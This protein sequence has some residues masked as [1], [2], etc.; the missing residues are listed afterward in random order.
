MAPV[1]V[2]L[3][4]GLNVSQT[5]IRKLVSKLVL[6]VA[7]LPTGYLSI[8]VPRRGMPLLVS[9]S[10]RFSARRSNYPAPPVSV[11]VRRRN[12]PFQS[13]WDVLKRALYRKKTLKVN[14]CLVVFELIIVDNLLW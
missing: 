6:I 12:D 9:Q 2:V 7:L 13:L 14:D 8:S 11:P 5:I 3:I 1:Y 4:A 10:F